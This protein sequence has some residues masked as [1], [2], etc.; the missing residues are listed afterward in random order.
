MIRSRCSGVMLRTRSR[1]LARC[2]GVSFLNQI[3]RF[4]PIARGDLGDTEGAALDNGEK[5]PHALPAIPVMPHG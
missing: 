1:S 2:S 4:I 3:Q 5:I